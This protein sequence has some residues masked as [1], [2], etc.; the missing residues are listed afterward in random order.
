M[1][2]IL[3][4]N[5]S[6]EAKETLSNMKTR[7]AFI[8]LLIFAIHLS[9]YAENI[10]RNP[11]M[12]D[13]AANGLPVSWNVRNGTWRAV[14]GGFSLGAGAVAVQRITLPLDGELRVQASITATKGLKYRL[15]AEYWT[16]KK[17]DGTGERWMN[18]G[19]DWIEGTGESQPFER[20]FKVAFKYDHAHFAVMAAKG[21]GTVECRGLTLETFE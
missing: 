17:P 1:W 15:Y 14:E 11:L 21:D 20:I 18:S 16:D 6:T 12:S 4:K 10:L 19:A 5:Y 8:L 13:K 3:M 7:R 2:I 9:I